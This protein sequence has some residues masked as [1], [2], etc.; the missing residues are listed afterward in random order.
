[1]G[2]RAGAA[3][4][5][6]SRPP[7]PSRGDRRDSHRSRPRAGTRAALSRSGR[8]ATAGV[9]PAAS[10]ASAQRMP[11]PPAFVSTATRRPRG[12]GWRESS[13]ATSSSSSSVSARRTPVWR[14]SASTAASEPASAAVCELAARAPGRGVAALHREDRLRACDPPGDTGELAWVAERL[15]VE[16]DE[17]RSP[18]RPPTT[19]AGRSTRHRPCCRSRRTPRGR[20]RVRRPLR[21]APGRARRSATRSRCSRT[22]RHS[23]RRSRSTTIAATAT[24]RQFGPISRPPCARTSPSSSCWRAAPSAPVSAKPAEITHSARMPRRRHASAELED[25]LARHADHGEID[26]VGD[27][28]DGGVAV[29]ARDGDALAVDGVCGAGEVRRRM[30]R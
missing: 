5:A 13:A 21:S 22:A 7:S 16:Q 20:A 1:M 3:P 17:P 27:L 28:V 14:K 23:G 12:S 2:R 8:R 4:R 26:L 15:E 29:H 9:R 25:E 11:S 10:H 19:R 18:R 24:P 6:R 30:L